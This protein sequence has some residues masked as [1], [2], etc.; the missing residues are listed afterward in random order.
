MT[1]DD[2]ILAEVAL[3]SELA[4]SGGVGFWTWNIKENIAQADTVSALLFNVSPAESRIGVPISTILQ[5]IHPDD[6]DRISPKILNA[7]HSIK[8]Y[9]AEYRVVSRLRV[10]RRLFTRGQFYMDKDGK[11]AISRGVIVDIT[12]ARRQEEA[13][14]I[15][16]DYSAIDPLNRA[17]DLCL[18]MHDEISK[19]GNYKLL[20]TVETILLDLGKTMASRYSLRY[21]KDLH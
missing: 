16:E 14:A 5:A 15:S 21:N 18:S 19:V 17:A 7:D 3:K 1:D 12:D 11:P 9:A 8:A 2:V 6:L 10:T 20:M 4:T 13:H